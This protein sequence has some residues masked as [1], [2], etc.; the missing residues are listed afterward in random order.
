[1][2]ERKLA[3]FQI[4]DHTGTNIMGDG[5]DPTDLTTYPSFSLIPPNMAAHAATKL[6]AGQLL[7]PLFEGDVEEAEPIFFLDAELAFID[8]RE[9]AIAETAACL[10]EAA[11][12]VI[13]NK[14]AYHSYGTRMAQG[15]DTY[16]TA[17][18]RCEVIALAPACV[19]EWN[20][21]TDAE[22]DANAPYDWDFVPAFLE[23]H[24]RDHGLGR[25]IP[26]RNEVA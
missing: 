17:G 1:M 21:L 10:W 23:R 18:F 12:N 24:V 22:Q 15:L 5:T 11:Q 16:G 25:A 8:T 20:R 14:D 9:A 4:T 19:A 13:N 6:K 7:Q 3:G 2:H 26:G